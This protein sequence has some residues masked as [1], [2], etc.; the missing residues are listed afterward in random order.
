MAPYKA[1][2][3]K[4]FINNIYIYF[5]LANTHAPA[6]HMPPV[7]LTNRVGVLKSIIIRHYFLIIYILVL[8]ATLAD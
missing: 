6:S 3:T 2:T 8:G 1:I 4:I 7:S 5:H